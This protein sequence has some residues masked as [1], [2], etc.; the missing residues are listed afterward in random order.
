MSDRPRPRRWLPPLIGGIALTALVLLLWVN[1]RKE[2]PSEADRAAPTKPSWPPVPESTPR[3]YPLPKPTETRFHNAG[4]D[5]RFVGT[6]ACI[7]CH[8]GNHESYLLTPHSRALADLDPGAEPPDGE[9][10]HQPSGRQYR[11]YRKDGQMRHEE[12]V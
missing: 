2:E 4:P 10:D 5:A 6:D 3:D 1:L 8:S 9:F 12:V 7:E 11:V